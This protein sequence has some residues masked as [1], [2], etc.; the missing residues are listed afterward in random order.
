MNI[1]KHF[2]YRN[3]GILGWIGL[4]LVIAGGFLPARTWQD[5]VVS[6]LG[7]VFALISFA[8][9]Y[10]ERGRDKGFEEGYA[11]ASVRVVEINFGPGTYNVKEFGAQGDGVTDDTEAIQ[12]A[13]DAAFGD[14]RR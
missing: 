2:T 6:T 5:F 11:A 9:V 1:K 8:A 14:G 7:F 10:H 4:A 3:A 12:A 13:M